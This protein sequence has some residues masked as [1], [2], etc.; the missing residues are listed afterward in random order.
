MQ[1]Q[2]FLRFRECVLL[3][4]LFLSGAWMATLHDRLPFPTLPDIGES[5][6]NWISLLLAIDAAFSSSLLASCVLPFI[7]FVFGAAGMHEVREILLVGFPAGARR[8]LLL[9]IT[10]TMHFSLCAW[11]MRT[12]GCIQHILYGRRRGGM[13]YLLS[14]FIMLLGFLVSAVTAGILRQL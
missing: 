6:M 3:L 7:T 12:A 9:L 4:V 2:R 10:V 14:V 1:G 13:F 11:A 8:F 5:G